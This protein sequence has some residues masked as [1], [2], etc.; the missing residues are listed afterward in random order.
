MIGQ[1]RGGGT[2]LGTGK[3]PRDPILECSR[4]ACWELQMPKLTLEMDLGG[5]KHV[6]YEVWLKSAKVGWRSPENGI[7][8]ALFCPVS[9]LRRG[10]TN[11]GVSTPFWPT[12]FLHENLRSKPELL[13]ISRQSEANMRAQSHKPQ[14]KSWVH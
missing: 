6:G 7:G 8:L 5:R 2:R 13:F 4:S 9:G 1:S 11:S 12:G 14:K 10:C 3:V